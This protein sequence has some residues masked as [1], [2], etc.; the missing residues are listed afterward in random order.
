MSEPDDTLRRMNEILTDELAERFFDENI[1]PRRLAEGCGTPEIDDER[2]RFVAMVV[3]SRKEMASYGRPA[4]RLGPE[5]QAVLRTK[6]G[7]EL[8]EDEI[9]G[10]VEEA[11]RGYDVDAP[12]VHRWNV[13]Q[14]F[15]F[16]DGEFGLEAETALYKE[17][18]RREMH[19][20]NFRYACYVGAPTAVTAQACAQAMLM[21]RLRPH[22]LGVF[23]FDVRLVCLGMP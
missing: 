11:E 13:G 17:G 10:Y 16:T 9:A 2:A 23:V 18:V 1:L 19:P 6:T 5:E 7:R 15:V 8:T 12:A 20:G 21:D 4:G 22:G 14:K 3:G